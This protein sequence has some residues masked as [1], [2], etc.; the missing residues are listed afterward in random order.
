MASRCD[1]E[2]STLMPPVSGRGFRVEM[3]TAFNVIER[4]FFGSASPVWPVGPER[5]PHVHHREVAR[6]IGLSETFSPFG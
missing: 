1:R 3:A 6:A 4:F 2:I 5:I